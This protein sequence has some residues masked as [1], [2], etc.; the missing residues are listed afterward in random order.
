MQIEQENMLLPQATVFLDR[1]L[2]DAL[3]YY[4]FL[5]LPINQKLVDAI[6]LYR[7]KKIFIL[8]LLLLI[9]DYARKEDE[10]AQ[11]KIHQL[12]IEVYKELNYPITYVPVLPP[13]DRVHFIL[14]NL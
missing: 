12:L 9:Q 3:A 11:K 2:P 5:T 14:N 1:A 8:D 6:K 4:R 10:K 13:Q 7:Y